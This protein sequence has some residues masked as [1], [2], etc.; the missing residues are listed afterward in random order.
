M[1]LSCCQIFETEVNSSTFKMKGPLDSHLLRRSN[2]WVEYLAKVIT[3]GTV[4][5]SVF[6][7]VGYSYDL[8]RHGQQKHYIG[9][10]S[11]AGFVLLT[12]PI[13]IRLI[14]QHL[15]HW[16]APHIQKYV[17]RIIWMVPIY[18]IE[19][20]LALRFKSLSIYLETLRECYEAYVI[21]SFLYFLIALL[22]E[23]TQLIQK[24]KLK[25]AEFGRHSWPISLFVSPWMMGS[26]IL[27]KCKF[28]VF[29][30]VLIKN[31]FAILV[32]ILASRGQYNEGKFRFDG[33]YLYQCFICNASQL[34]ALYCLIL[35][36]F[37]TKE[38]LSPWRPVGKF[39]CV[40]TVVFFT[41]WQSIIINI[42][43][44]SL[45]NKSQDTGVHWTNNEISKG[46]QV[47]STQNVA[48]ILYFIAAALVLPF[49]LQG[50]PQYFFYILFD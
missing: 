38:E 44:T 20:W 26:E 35:F 19:S 1:S 18:S 3:I 25:S 37:A 34:W 15:T 16:N 11:S 32:C 40:K 8:Y 24:L 13:S 5:I 41:W 4:V 7:I 49:C 50:C 10:F 31:I 23:E 33:L 43:A 22:G 28:G 21:F 2:T 9:W 29:Q 48:F 27:Q 47:S 36:Y 30:Y 46:L 42:L 12:I 17:V 6:G 45:S 39:L 14:V